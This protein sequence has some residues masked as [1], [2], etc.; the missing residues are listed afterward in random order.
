ML[1]LC[2]Y[3]ISLMF[4]DWGRWPPKTPQVA[5]LPRSGTIGD[6]FCVS[7]T[8]ESSTGDISQVIGCWCASKAHLPLIVLFP[9]INMAVSCTCRA[10][11]LLQIT[12]CVVWSVEH[13]YQNW[14][15]V[16]CE[17]LQQVRLYPGI[18]G[19]RFTW[20]YQ[21]HLSDLRNEK[22]VCDNR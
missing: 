7:W 2:P 3:R 12:T 17:A 22:C 9:M 20:W 10:C 1:K 16:L 18:I 6:I 19:T 4:P 15:L 13:C 21:S 14:Q 11:L 5:S 8:L